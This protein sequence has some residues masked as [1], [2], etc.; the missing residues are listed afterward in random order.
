MI[1]YLLLL[2]ALTSC[3]NPQDSKRQGVELSAFQGTVM[4]VPYKIEI[5]QKLSSSEQVKVEQIIRKTFQEINSIYNKW[6][7]ESEVSRI[8]QADAGVA[9]EVSPQLISFLQQCSSFVE[10]SQGRFDPTIESV[11]ALWK[12]HLEKDTT[13]SQSEIDQ[14]KGAVGWSNLIIHNT[15]VVKKHR[16]TRLDLGGIA[17]GYCVDL[18][19]ERLKKRGFKSVFVEWGG[20]IRAIGKHPQGRQWAVFISN[21]EDLN[22]EHALAYVPLT[23]QSIATSGDYLQQWK[24]GQKTYFHVFDPVTLRPLLVTDNSI[25]S[26]SVLTT[27]CMAADALATMLLMCGNM[28]E[29]KALSLKIQE[30]YPDATFWMMS[31]KE[32]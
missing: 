24:V 4:T 19:V 32:V 3:S 21:L 26:A 20:E 13:P 22:P 9:V 11:Q 29:A 18:L 17:K 23:N 5:G 7:P 27:E 31:R 28:E 30:K 25:A 2:L 8:N 12:A 15:S 14:L 6:N 16:K 1:K 10:L